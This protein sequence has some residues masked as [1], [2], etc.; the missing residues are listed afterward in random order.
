MKHKLLKLKQNGDTI[1]EV[2]IAI[3]VVSGVL[4]ATYSIM[5]RN[6]LLVRDNQERSEASKIAQSQLELLKNTW[7]HTNPN[8]FP[9]SHN[10]SFCFGPDRSIV[11][12]SSALPDNNAA[13]D[14]LSA[15]DSACIQDD[16]YHIGIRI[17]ATAA[18]RT[19]IVTVRWDKIGGGRNEVAMAYRLS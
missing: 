2:L 8:D 3:A 9:S 18:T 12:L 5:N 19:Y 15:Y 7:D 10:V 11:Y 1:V 16:V 6:M 4:G 13:D 17:N 14:E